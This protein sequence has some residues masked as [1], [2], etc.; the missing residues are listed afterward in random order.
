MV[1]AGKNL[2]VLSGE[3]WSDELRLDEDSTRSTLETST[4]WSAKMV[5]S[6]WRRRTLTAR[7]WMVFRCMA[8]MAEWSEKIGGLIHSIHSI[9]PFH[10]FQWVGKCWKIHP[11]IQKPFHPWIFF[12]KQIAIFSGHH[13]WVGSMRSPARKLHCRCAARREPIC[14]TRGRMQRVILRPPLRHRYVWFW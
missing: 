4:G 10:P 11:S 3:I 12:Q 5:R 1:E 6:H 2:W 14:T 9:H 8:C 13:W 7:Q